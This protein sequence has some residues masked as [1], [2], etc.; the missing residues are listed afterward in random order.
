MSPALATH[1]TAAIVVCTILSSLFA[2]IVSA[3]LWTRYVLQRSAAI[4]DL[5]ILIAA[6][7]FVYSARRVPY[8]LTLPHKVSTIALLIVVLLGMYRR[9]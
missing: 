4:E 8:M 3:R 2:P 6:V 1:Q 7:R 9:H 5:L